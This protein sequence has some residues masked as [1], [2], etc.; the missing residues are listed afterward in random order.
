MRG[1]I[2]AAGRQSLAADGQPTIMTNLA[3]KTLLDRQITALRSGGVTEV[4]VIRGYHAEAVTTTGVTWFDHP[5]W[6]ETGQ[7]M[8][9]SAAAEWLRSGTVIVCD[10]NIVFRHELVHT[11][12]SVRGA[13]VVGY[14][15][16]W[17]NLWTRRFAEPMT[18]VSAFRRGP[19]GNLLEIGGTA[20][21]PETVQGQPVGM[22]KITPT[23]WQAMEAFAGTLEPVVRDH[24]DISSLLHGLLDLKTIGIGTVGT[25]GQ[26]GRIESVTDVELYEQMAAAGELPLEG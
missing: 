2:L 23:A 12:G 24:L 19:A 14:D 20:E 15:R 22:L 26:W 7:V 5:R 1:L 6:A 21:D 3:G 4:G 9:L 25:D 13:L 18:H 11:I 8:A 10:G 17:R 16:S